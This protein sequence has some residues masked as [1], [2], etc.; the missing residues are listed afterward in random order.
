MELTTDASKFASD[1]FLSQNNKTTFFISRTLNKAEEH[2]AANEKQFLAVIW[3]LNSFQNYLY[4]PAKVE[5][6]TDQQPLIYPLSNN[7]N[8]SKMKRWKAILEEYN[9]E[10]LYKPSKANLV[11]DALSR[12]Q[13]ETD[14]IYCKK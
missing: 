10:L 8:N 6:Y 11:A 3:A 7:N 1:A 13:R 4:G 9:Y 2:Y 12:I 14:T 5:I